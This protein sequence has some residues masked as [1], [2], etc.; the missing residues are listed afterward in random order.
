MD[1][2]H[3]KDR[4]VL[5]GSEGSALT[6]PLFRIC[7]YILTKFSCYH[8]VQKRCPL[9]LFAILCTYVLIYVSFFFSF[10]LYFLFV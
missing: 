8:S 1:T 4:L 9:R 7:K 2:L 10:F 3:L 6:L 5:F